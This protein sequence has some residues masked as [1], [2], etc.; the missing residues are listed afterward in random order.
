MTVT[1][2]NKGF[3]YA[4]RTAISES[5]PY[6]ASKDPDG[7][8]NKR[9]VNERNLLLSIYEFKDMLDPNGRCAE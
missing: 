5:K 4:T 8:L 3:K 2:D 7:D 6:F 1:L 9:I